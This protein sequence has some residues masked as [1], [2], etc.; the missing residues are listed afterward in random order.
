[1]KTRK[2]IYSEMLW[3][4]L[5]PWQKINSKEEMNEGRKKKDFENC[6]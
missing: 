1:M 5:K 2:E 4:L 6:E 3:K